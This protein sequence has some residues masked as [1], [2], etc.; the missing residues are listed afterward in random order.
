M[1]KTRNI[2][3]TRGQRY[4][5]SKFRTSVPMLLANDFIEMYAAVILPWNFLILHKAL[6]QLE[7]Q[8]PEMKKHPEQK[9]IKPSVS[10]DAA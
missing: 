7:K 8:K 1:V 6:L 10:D 2:S 3:Q 5:R 4:D 9:I